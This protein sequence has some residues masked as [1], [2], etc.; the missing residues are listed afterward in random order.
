MIGTRKSKRDKPASQID[1]KAL[2]VREMF[3]DLKDEAD[4]APDCKVAWNLLEDA[5]NYLK[6]GNL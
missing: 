6:L 1:Y 2:A 5:N 4:G 3:S